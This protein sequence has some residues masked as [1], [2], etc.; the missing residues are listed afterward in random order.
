MRSAS[1]SR[2]SRRDES[3]H[4]RRTHGTTKPPEPLSPF[5]QTPHSS[6]HSAT[7]SRRRAE[8]V[9]ARSST[10]RGGHQCSSAATSADLGCPR[11]PCTPWAG[12]AR[13]RREGAWRWSGRSSPWQGDAGVD[14]I[15]E[16][17]LNR[18]YRVVSVNSGEANA[19]NASRPVEDYS[20]LLS[21]II[22]AG[23]SRGLSVGHSV[24]A[25]GAYPSG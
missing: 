13:T 11:S 3:P 23:M 7:A 1:G 15:E 19:L 8:Q 5:D 9:A 14:F 20:L 6:P 2:S 17:R 10:L 4:T 22:S 24:I 18:S 21:F 25:S 16:F 12:R